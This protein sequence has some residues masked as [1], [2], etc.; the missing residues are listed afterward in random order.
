VDSHFIQFPVQA[1]PADQRNWMRLK[2]TICSWNIGA[3]KLNQPKLRSI[4]MCR[5]ASKAGQVLELAKQD[6]VSPRR[7]SL[8]RAS[9]AMPDDKTGGGDW[10]AGYSPG[11]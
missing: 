8:R 9:G 10:P 5:G 3:R 2:R 11:L 1:F 7:Q 6:N 4:F